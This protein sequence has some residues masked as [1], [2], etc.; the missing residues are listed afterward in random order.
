MLVFF[1]LVAMVNI[2]RPDSDDEEQRRRLL[3]PASAVGIIGGLGPAI[4]TG[5]I[6]GKAIDAGSSLGAAAINNKRRRLQ[7]GE[8]IDTV[9]EKATR[10]IES[11]TFEQVREIFSNLDSTQ[12]GSLAKATRKVSEA[13]TAAGLTQCTLYVD[14]MK[15]LDADHV[16]LKGAWVDSF[17]SLRDKQTACSAVV[18]FVNSKFLSSRRLEVDAETDVEMRDGMFYAIKK[19]QSMLRRLAG[20]AATGAAATGIVLG[21]LCKSFVNGPMAMVEA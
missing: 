13:C 6:F 8:M 19:N 12:E 9:C 17:G 7:T 14:L 16:L 3:D 5:G 10:I 18:N 1:L 2:V 20:L 4:A 21:Q 11:E 15:F